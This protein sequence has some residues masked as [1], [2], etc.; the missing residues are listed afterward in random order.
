MKIKTT[1][2]NNMSNLSDEARAAINKYQR[3]WRSKN[4]DK[5]NA[6]QTK[7]WAKKGK[8]LLANEELEKTGT[9]TGT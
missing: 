9:K 3:D 7:H 5:V 4:K 8:E 6:H 1:G 2:G